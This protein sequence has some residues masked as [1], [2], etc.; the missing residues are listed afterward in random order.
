ME[1]PTDPSVQRCLGIIGTT[2]SMG[3]AIGSQMTK[4]LSSLGQT[5]LSKS[6]LNE[7]NLIETPSITIYAKM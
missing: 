4:M 2:K 7:E 6:I 3:A 5:L 1:M